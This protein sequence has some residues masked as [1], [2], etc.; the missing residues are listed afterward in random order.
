M[1]K[2]LI[3]LVLFA[4]TVFLTGCSETTTTSSGT[5]IGGTEGLKTT[6][7]TGSPPEKI[8][9]GGTSGFSI[10]VKLENVGESNIDADDGYVQ[11]QGIDANI[12]GAEETNFKKMFS[13]Q[14][15]FGDT[16]LGARRGF[17]GKTLNGG[18]A[19]VEFGNLAYS[20]ISQGDMQQTIVAD[21]CYRYTTKAVTQLCVKNNVE[22]ALSSDNI[23]TL[24]GEKSIQNSGGPIQVTSLKESYAGNGK[25]GIT[26]TISH[27]GTGSAFFKYSDLNCNNVASNMDKGKVQVKFDEVQVSGKSVPVVC[28]GID[29]DEYIRLYGDSTTS[30]GESYNLY[31]TVDTS[32]SDNVVEVPLNLELNYVYLQSV[33]TSLTIRHVTK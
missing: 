33:S 14:D 27:K 8:T 16:L 10:V 22:Q 1:N 13:A 26:L 25:I 20:L 5:F 24:E 18:I 12:Y 6:F 30:G 21:V 2:G 19:T 23:C 31:C 32:G 11:I 15:N 9:D 7:L 4:M 28:Q 3:L 17:D 29:D